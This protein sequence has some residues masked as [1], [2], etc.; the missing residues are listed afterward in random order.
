MARKPANLTFEQAACVPIAAITALQ[1]LRD[2]GR[3]QAGQKVLINGA[4][5]GVGTFAVQIAKSF[6]ADVTG[7]CS[8][9]NVDL[10]RSLGADRVIDYTKD[11]FTAG[12]E[13]YD[14]ILDNVGNRSVSDCRRVLEPRGKYVLVGGGGVEDGRWVGPI[15]S[16]IKMPLLS[17]FVSQDLGMM[18]ANLNAKDLGLLADLMQAGKV[19]PVI[20]K[21]YALS[22]TD[23]AI[24]Y[25]E[26]GHARGKVVI[27]VEPDDTS[28][29]P[30]RLAAQPVSTAKPKLIA[31]ALI[32]IL[33]GVPGVPI[34]AALALNRR[35]RRRNP[36]KRPYRWGYYFGIQSFVA[37]AGLGLLV[38]PGLGAAILI[39]LA[40]AVL[41]WRFVQRDHWAWVTLTILSFNPVAW[42]INAVY[43][44]KRW[45][46]DSPAPAQ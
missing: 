45:G 30:A 42:I 28:A 18:M 6:G 41:A 33:L 36:G 15:L 35:F 14:L 7:V 22:E 13:R 20:D 34:V 44:R 17:R 32:G 11:D 26:A 23:E 24:R 40:Y 5:G 10:V 16:L 38:E 46:E 43:F 25:L 1:A 27:H 2:N 39:G 9:R 3:L 21:R 29:V 8:T 12:G 31:L 37:G 4:S 19:T